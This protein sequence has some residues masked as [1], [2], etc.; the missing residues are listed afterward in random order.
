MACGIKKL[1]ENLKTELKRKGFSNRAI[2]QALEDVS[3]YEV[4]RGSST[5]TEFKESDKLSSQ[6]I[7]MV[8]DYNSVI[9]QFFGDD[10]Q[11]GLIVPDQDYV[12][13]INE[14]TEATA[15]LFKTYI[16]DYKAKLSVYQTHGA[17]KGSFTTDVRHSNNDEIKL[18][19]SNTSRVHSATEIF[20]HES[21]HSTMKGVL[22][23]DN[24]LKTRLKKLKGT[25]IDV[26]KANNISYEVFLNGIDNPTKTE[27]NQAKEAYQ[28]VFNPEQDV[29]EF[30]AYVM[31]NSRLFS[32]IKG[33]DVEQT[34]NGSPYTIIDIFKRVVK[35]IK[36]KLGILAQEPT[37][38]T[39][40]QNELKTIFDDVVVARAKLE[41]RKRGDYALA[42][43]DKPLIHKTVVFSRPYIDKVI[44][45]PLQT[46][47][48]NNQYQRVKDE[49]YKVSDKTY[50]LIKNSKR[51]QDVGVIIKNIDFMRDIIY[52]STVQ[53][54]YHRVFTLESESESKATYRV[55]RQL[56]NI[57][58]EML[59]MEHRVYEHLNEKFGTKENLKV[60]DLTVNKLIKYGLNQRFGTMQTDDFRR[61]SIEADLEYFKNELRKSNVPE[62]SIKEFESLAEFIYTGKPNKAYQQINIE[63][64]LFGDSRTMI[65]IDPS[66]H[67][68]ANDYVSTLLL[69]KE[70]DETLVE[71]S[72]L[73]NN[74]DVKAHLTRINTLERDFREQ[75]G[76]KRNNRKFNTFGRVL[77]KINKS[78][79]VGTK[80]EATAYGAK[81]LSD[82]PVITI[83]GVEIYQYIVPD[84]TPNIDSG[85]LN[86]S[87]L[88]IEGTKI[89]HILSK[90]LD[91]KRK[92]SKKELEPEDKKLV[93]DSV[94]ANLENFIDE[95]D[96][97]KFVP[98]Y[99]SFGKIS[100]F[101]IPFGKDDLNQEIQ[102]NTDLLKD[103]AN[104]EYSIARFTEE[105]KYKITVYKALVKDNI[106]E[107]K[108]TT[109]LRH[110][111]P[112]APALYSDLNIPNELVPALSGVRRA[113]IINGKYIK[114]FLDKNPSVK[115]I[116][117]F[118]EKSI[119]EVGSKFKQAL[120]LFTPAIVAGN[121]AS[122]AKVLSEEGLNYGLLIERFPEE[123]VQMKEFHKL[124]DKKLKLELDLKSG[125]D[126]TD[127]YLLV[128]QQ[129]NENPYNV[130]Y[131]Y[132][133]LNKNVDDNI[134]PNDANIL[135]NIQEKLLGKNFRNLDAAIYQE[136]KRLSEENGEPLDDNWYK[137]KRNIKKQTLGRRPKTSKAL[138]NIVDIL[139]GNE[140]SITLNTAT[141][142]LIAGDAITKKLLLDYKINQ[143]P[144]LDIPSYMNELSDKF[145]NYNT[146]QSAIMQWVE[147]IGLEFFTKYLFAS[148]K[149]YFTTAKKNPGRV[150]AT[151][152]FEAITG[153]NLTS[154][155]DNFNEM[156]LEQTT[157][158]LETRWKLDDLP[159]LVEANALPHTAHIFSHFT[160]PFFKGN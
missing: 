69:N 15:E 50:H 113:T 68:L 84:Y 38:T 34:S 95:E 103:A 48:S 44:M 159:E 89:S 135:P 97:H 127:E 99:D 130:L 78:I 121:I 62:T 134:N 105:Q 144:N 102:Y 6:D 61:D 83:E 141:D 71:L 155:D 146:P 5:F 122:N 53:D 67:N 92:F 37:P 88:D 35:L 66:I 51:L 16:P 147:K 124:L 33:L 73:L 117:G 74:D 12:D 10:L 158:P 108:H 22:K 80:K 131:E 43:I 29:E 77:P 24:R 8:D 110:I 13:H 9:E 150:F 79:R 41:G 143:N 40:L 87:S 52:S 120:V 114:E 145:V 39:E 111:D 7:N 91:Q 60:L 132:G 45:K 42:H 112:T 49:I 139:Y 86:T 137:A 118:V 82:K 26:L 32:V 128:M 23:F 18:A 20:L 25:V 151:H 46:V 153:L 2:A 85:A 96:L 21:L 106:P 31:T 140:N 55:I 64:I 65:D 72:K 126:K 36:E 100:D 14:F 104:I 59:E 156:V 93:L 138:N 54:I 63:N 116:I 152:A 81:L 27:I 11:N 75:I 57:N 115:N 133:H 76:Y 157:K 28:Y 119:E 129:I 101:V 125:I 109:K 90:V 98:I 58:S 94:I 1:N 70:S 154:P 19:I 123:F 148:M 136:A 160:N 142:L 3:K 107:S 17:T 149:G 30:F 56:E 47:I 4:Y